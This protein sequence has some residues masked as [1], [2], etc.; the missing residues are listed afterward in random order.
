VRT[1]KPR[2]QTDIAR[3][4]ASE[5]GKPTVTIQ[6]PDSKG[7]S[8]QTRS[9]PSLPGPRGT[10]PFSSRGTSLST[11][12]MNCSGATLRASTVPRASEMVAMEPSGSISDEKVSWM[13]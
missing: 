8:A 10:V 1:A 13:R 3:S 6:G 9:T 7:A 5:V 2:D 11:V 4:K 12:P